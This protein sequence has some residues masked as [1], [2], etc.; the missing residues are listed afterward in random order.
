MTDKNLASSYR[1][2]FRIISA[3]MPNWKDKIVVC[4]D[5][6]DMRGANDAERMSKA[7]KRMGLIIRAIRFMVGDKPCNHCKI[8]DNA[9]GT[10]KTLVY[11]NAGYYVNIGA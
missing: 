1:R 4:I 11:R 6:D 7:V 5:S 8:Y 9:D 10:G 3:D 2:I